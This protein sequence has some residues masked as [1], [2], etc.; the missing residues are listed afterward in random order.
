MPAAATRKDEHFEHEAEHL[1]L[2][3]CVLDE[4]DSQV[5]THTVAFFLVVIFTFAIVFLAVHILTFKS[6]STI[7]PRH[8]FLQAAWWWEE[9]MCTA[10]FLRDGESP[11]WVGV[12]D[13]SI[14]KLMKS[15]F[16]SPNT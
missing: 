7:F 3:N 5:H 10:A 6:F 11:A 4:Y 16:F 13:A 9:R 14:Q 12:P 1:F 15:S 2:T 8:L